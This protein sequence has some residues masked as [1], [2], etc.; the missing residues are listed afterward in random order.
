MDDEQLE[1]TNDDM[2]GGVTPEERVE[3]LQALNN[4]QDSLDHQPSIP[5]ALRPTVLAAE[6]MWRMQEGIPDFASIE[7]G[8]RVVEVPEGIQRDDLMRWLWKTLIA[9]RGDSIFY[10]AG[11]SSAILKFGRRSVE[12]PT[13]LGAEPPKFPAACWLIGSFF[14]PSCRLA[15][16]P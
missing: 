5:D 4:A 2:E 3:Y 12:T 1:L 8:L 7:P 14:Y 13:Y 9:S 10:E 15:L 6:A 16:A 11:P